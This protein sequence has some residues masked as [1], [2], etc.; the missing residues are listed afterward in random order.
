MQKNPAAFADI[1]KKNSDDPGSAAK[2]GDLDFF[3]RGAM[4]K[5]FEDAAFALKPGEISGIVETDFGYHI[6]KVD[7]VR[8]GEKKSFEQVRPEIEDEVRKQLAQK[9][10]RRRGGRVHDMVYE[11]PDSLKPVA[12]KF[13]LEIKTAQHVTRTPAPG[14]TGAAR[15]PKFLEALFSSD[16]TANKRNTEAIEIGA[17]QLAAGASCSTA[18]RTSCRSPK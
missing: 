6:I 15:Q 17:N 13:K 10:L 18:R 7:G 9:Q 12:D 11:Q 3:A 8:G 4:V 5:P 14:A 16:A 2:G 1:A